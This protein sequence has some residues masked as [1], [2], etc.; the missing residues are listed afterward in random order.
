[1]SSLFP[2]LFE[3]LP[4]EKSAVDFAVSDFWFLLQVIRLPLKLKYACP[5]QSTWKLAVESLL[6]IIHNGLSVH[7][8]GENRGELICI[9]SV[10]ITLDSF[11]NLF[12]PLTK[13]H[14]FH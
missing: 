2:F 6:K 10:C 4:D 3:S 11:Y 13:I 1:M 14:L 5:A 9:Y 7:L 8:N 12:N